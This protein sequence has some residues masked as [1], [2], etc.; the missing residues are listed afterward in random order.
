MHFIKCTF[1]QHA[2]EILAIFN[3]A[4][5]NTT[6]LYEYKPRTLETMKNWFHTKT[7]N[8]FP[9][10]GATNE[11]GQLLGFASY[12]TFRAWAAYKYSIEHSVYVHKNYRGKG[13]GTALIQKLILL[14]KQQQ[15][16][17][18]IGA[19]DIDNKSSIA[20]HE[21]LGFTHAGTIKEAGFKFGHWLDFAF[22]QLILETP[23]MPV[24][25]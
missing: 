8:N 10:I 2:S 23:K 13:L 5:L 14:A 20:L 18:M 7:E 4:I 9:I 3:D 21:R 11:T 19:I 6:A 22:Y 24:D 25:G 1:E 12:G 15:Y 17:T 16:H